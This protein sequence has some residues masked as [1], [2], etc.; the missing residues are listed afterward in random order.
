M[1]YDR[2][3]IINFGTSSDMSFDISRRIRLVNVSALLA[4]VTTIPYLIIFFSKELPIAWVA[5][6]FFLS[7]CSCWILNKYRLYSL[8][9]SSL[10]IFSC[11]YLFIVAS[12]LGRESAHQLMLI[13]VLLSVVLV[14]EF[15]EKT[16]LFLMIGLILM[17]FLFLELTDYALLSADITKAEQLYFYYGSLSVAILGTATIGIFYFFLYGRQLKENQA[18]IRKSKEI[19]RTINY[20]S[21][22]LFGKNTVDEILW[23]VAKN[24]IGRLGFVDCVIYLLDEEKQ[25]LVQKAAYGNK[26]PNDFE[27]YAPIDIP[28]G[29][30]IVGHVAKLGSALLVEDTSKDSRYIADDETR[31]SE[32]A[33]PLI[34]NNKLIGVIDSEHPEK[35]FFTQHHLDILNTISSLCA[36]KVI[37]AMAEM[38]REKALKVQLEAEKIK[39]FDELKTKLFANV[40][41]E[42]RTPLTLIVGTIDRHTNKGE[43]EDWGLLKQHTDRLLRLINQLLDLSK[44]ESGQFKLNPTPGDI[45]QFLRTVSALFS[46]YAADRHVKIIEEIPEG[47]LWLN[48]DYDALEKIFFNL[49]SNA[50][51]FT[52]ENTVVKLKV[53]DDS[54]F[55]VQVIDQGEGIPEG[56]YNKIFDRYYQIG[57]Q[58][59]E[60]TGIGLALTKELVN[61]QKGHLS[62]DST[63]GIGTTFSVILPL[64]NAEKLSTDSTKQEPGKSHLNK[65][66]K[67][68]FEETG[69]FVLLVEDNIEV[70]KLIKSTLQE[71]LYIIHANNGHE[72]MSIA[73]NRIP[74]LIISD[75]MMPNM[76]GMKF[77]KWVRE[78]E[79]TSHIPFIFLT[80]RADNDTKLKGLEIGADDFLTK[81]FSGQELEIR[82]ANLIE[83]RNMLAEK[84]RKIISLEPTNIVVTSIEEIF[85]KKLLNVVSE[86]IDN[87]DFNVTDLSRS[88]GISRMQLHRKIT[89]LTGHSATSFIRHQRLIQASKLLE[90]GESVSQVAYAVGFSSLS[91]FSRV[92]KDQFGVLPSEFNLED[93]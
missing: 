4:A 45:Y 34:Y 63:P 1:T 72:A 15:E 43:S 13:P 57:Q 6:I 53:V 28:M 89:A 47:S 17:C 71:K 91:Y 48:F 52:K 55:S 75:I 64:D 65:E 90:A 36:N 40:S 37:R 27:I 23:D 10:Y 62:V 82:V 19:E 74:D 25:L 50:I 30:G 92:F 56:E 58:S 51:K 84:Y 85:L 86:N 60:G 49:I 26:N 59:S 33:V 42:L 24:C 32:L 67:N 54:P 41:H 20:F 29:E 73:K 14:Y 18:M 5:L 38:E 61:L 93:T 69:S 11:I 21:T 3:N 16:S 46:S 8:A 88:L 2:I 39:S 22:S 68:T 31:L 87:S 66:L 83:G 81:P 35:N 12:T 7:Y 79:L 9:R 80:A 44:L 70:A 78:N 76:D 77:C